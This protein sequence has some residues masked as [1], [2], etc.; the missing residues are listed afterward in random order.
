VIWAVGDNCDDDH[1]ALDCDDVGRLIA[2]DPATDA[3]L[4]MGDLQYENASLAKLNQ[5]YDPKMGAGKGLKAKTYPAP[6]NHEYLSSEAAG[7]FDYWRARAGDRSWATAASR[8]AAGRSSLPTQCA[9]RL[10]AAVRPVGKASSSP[11]T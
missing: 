4:A 2:N 7:Y 10:A 9:P 1:A 6:G 3:V 11:R 8:W 5:Y